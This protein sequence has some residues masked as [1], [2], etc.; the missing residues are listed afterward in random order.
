M[1]SVFRFKDAHPFGQARFA[2]FSC[3][4]TSIFG[5]G[6]TGRGRTGRS[7]DMLITYFAVVLIC[8]LLQLFHRGLRIG[9]L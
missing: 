8:F 1:F 4:P 9:L 6:R 2:R 3:L 7:L 5:D